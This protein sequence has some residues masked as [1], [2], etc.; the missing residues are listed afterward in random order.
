L[1]EINGGIGINLGEMF[2]TIE[3]NCTESATDLQNIIILRWSSTHLED[4]GCMSSTGK[5]LGVLIPD[6]M[7]HLSRLGKI[8]PLE[9]EL[10]DV[11]VELIFN[12][13]VLG[14]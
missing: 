7:P 13:M 9:Y 1:V 5:H 14:L 4:I 11:V 3:R 12:S 2:S 10:V 8:K 6:P